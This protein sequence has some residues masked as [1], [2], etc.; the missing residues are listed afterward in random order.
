GASQRYADAIG[1]TYDQMIAD[2]VA[3][4]TIIVEKANR[5]SEDCDALLVVVSDYT[6]VAGPMEFGFNA[7]VAANLGAPIILV[8]SARHRS[9][10]LVARAAESAMADAR[11]HHASVLAVIANRACDDQLADV[12]SA[13]SRV[14]CPA[15]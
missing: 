1:V 12:R 11:L 13:L 10:E 5:L 4:M 9:P 3:A 14:G 15:Y 2:P 8:V 6:D 7:E